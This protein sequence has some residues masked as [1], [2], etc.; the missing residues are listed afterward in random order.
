MSHRASSLIKG[1]SLPTLIIKKNIY[2]RYLQKK[3]NKYCKINCE[4]GKKFK[5]PLNKCIKH[6]SI[7]INTQFFFP[8]I[9]FDLKRK[10][11]NKKTK[12]WRT[13]TTEMCFAIASRSKYIDS[14]V[15]FYFIWC[16]LNILETIEILYIQIL[17]SIHVSYYSLNTRKNNNHFDL[18]M[19]TIKILF[20]SKRRIW[21]VRFGAN[22]YWFY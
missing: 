3:L 20:I 14:S 22:Y 17:V 2:D 11:Q 6:V 1:T 4:I 21:F 10:R 5:N 7:R 15:L 13:K 8:I 18:M 9:E 12:S 16:P 19:K